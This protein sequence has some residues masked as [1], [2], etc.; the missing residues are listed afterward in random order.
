M[1]H[2]ICIKFDN[3]KIYY[4]INL[5]FF[6]ACAGQPKPVLTRYPGTLLGFQ[7]YELLDFILLCDLFSSIPSLKVISISY[8]ITV[9][10]MIRL[11]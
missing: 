4:S 2:G 10:L 1:S 8:Y 3:Q 9:A 6:V 7:N 11:P 5:Y